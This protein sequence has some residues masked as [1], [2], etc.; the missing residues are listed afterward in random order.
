M[1]TIFDQSINQRSIQIEGSYSKSS[2]VAEFGWDG[3]PGKR[4]GYLYAFAQVG[5]LEAEV[6]R[7]ALVSGRT[8]A[9]NPPMSFGPVSLKVQILAT[10]PIPQVLRL[11]RLED[12]DVSSGGDSSGGGGGRRDLIKLVALPST[13]GNVVAPGLAVFTAGHTVFQLPSANQ[14]DYHQQYLVGGDAFWRIGARSLESFSTGRVRFGSGSGRSVLGLAP[15]FTTV[16]FRLVPWA[17]YIHSPS[18]VRPMDRVDGAVK[19]RGAF[20]WSPDKEL[21]LRVEGGRVVY[22]I[23]EGEGWEA[24]YESPHPVTEPLYFCVVLGP[25]AFVFNCSIS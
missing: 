19:S 16:D 23:Q 9:F 18:E 2:F 20:D 4:K 5:E 7:V 10:E 14:P 6:A 13:D 24:V 8:L 12:S 3:E 17:W 21:A 22:E 11:W 1:E 15:E 25:Q